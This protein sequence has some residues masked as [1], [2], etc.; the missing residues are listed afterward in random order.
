MWRFLSRLCH[1]KMYKTVSPCNGLS[2]LFKRLNKWVEI[3]A[4][5]ST[6]I[7][8]HAHTR[9]RSFM[10]MMYVRSSKRQQQSDQLQNVNL[11]AM[12]CEANLIAFIIYIYRRVGIGMIVV[13]FPPRP[14][15]N[16]PA[17]LY[18]KKRYLQLKSIKKKIMKAIYKKNGTIYYHERVNR[19]SGNPNIGNIQVKKGDAPIDI[20][21]QTSKKI[22]E[23]VDIWTS[24]A[25]V[26]VCTLEYKE[27]TDLTNINIKCDI[28]NFCLR[29]NRHGASKFLW[30]LEFNA[31][32]K[33][34][35]HILY[36]SENIIDVQSLWNH[37]LVYFSSFNER[38]INSLST[39]NLSSYISKRSDVP[40]YSATRHKI[41][42][43]MSDNLREL[44]YPRGYVTDLPTDAK[45]LGD[46]AY[47][48]KNT[49]GYEQFI[50]TWH[51]N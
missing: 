33:G 8:A 21:L 18:K 12:R 25:N 40:N 39:S 14:D 9:A 2:F 41:K 22:R 5:I 42:H 47:F 49:S 24:I 11:K 37:G 6:P 17:V 45:Q 30:R 20:S 1:S 15:G 51:D 19:G 38:S 3:L 34:H 32:G 36:E 7:Y 46:F 26:N 50:E 48:S 35:F 28:K 16:C 31:D 44:K 27:W 23:V 4:S 13:A 10:F 29:L 43:G